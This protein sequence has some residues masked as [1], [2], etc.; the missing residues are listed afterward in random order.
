MSKK[1]FNESEVKTP[2]SRGLVIALLK[3]LG[4]FFTDTLVGNW[5]TENRNDE[6]RPH[7]L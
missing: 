2:D 5:D 6:E 4:A 1:G 7:V 3:S